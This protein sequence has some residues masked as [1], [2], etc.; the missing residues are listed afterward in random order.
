MA[1]SQSDSSDLSSKEAV[2]DRPNRPVRRTTK[3]ARWTKT[4]TP[5][6]FISPFIIIFSVFTAFPLIFSAY[7]S[8]QEW[9][10]VAGLSSMQYVGLENYRAAMDDPWMWKSLYNTAWL[11]IVSGIPQHLIA[12]PIAYLLVTAVRGGVSPE[13][14]ASGN[15]EMAHL[16][17]VPGL[18]RGC[19]AHSLAYLL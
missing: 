7:L 11:A 19:Y 14:M 5:W 18:D 9:N 8:F 17:L 2:P 15:I 3:R 13:S 12:I 6:L 10:P 16:F 4:L 1:V